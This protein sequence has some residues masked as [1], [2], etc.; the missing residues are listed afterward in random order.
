MLHKAFCFYE[1]IFMELS[2]S[3]RNQLPVQQ[4]SS[5]SNR[6]GCTIFNFKEKIHPARSYF[7][8]HVY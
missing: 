5:V 2:G 8:L 1:V 7:G 3:S 6:S 4:Y